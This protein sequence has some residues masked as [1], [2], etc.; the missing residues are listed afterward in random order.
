[1]VDGVAAV[2]LR[3]ARPADAAT[4]AEIWYAGWGDAHLGN[5]PD[6]LIVARTRESFDTRAVQYIPNIIVAT[7]DDA[8]AGFVMVIDDE[9][10]QVYVAAGHRGAGI[11]PIL[12][13][14]A[15]SRVRDNGHQRAWLAVVPGNARARK[16]YANNGWSDEG[17]FM[18]VAHGPAGTIDVPCHR[19]VK[20]VDRQPS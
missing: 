20:S 16:F 3:A 17:P 12:L 2:V 1:M 11:A 18:L 4:V 5:V 6:G 7:V 13:A 15:E 19:Y 14:A 10:N 8:I 9:V